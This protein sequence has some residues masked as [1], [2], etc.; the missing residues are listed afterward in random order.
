ME[1]ERLCSGMPQPRL[2][3]GI[4]L[5]LLLCCY[6]NFSDEITGVLFWFRYAYS[7]YFCETGI[8]DGVDAHSVCTGI[9]MFAELCAHEQQLFPGEET[10]EEGKL[11]PLPKTF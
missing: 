11:G 5:L 2:S 9:E 3:H 4:Y 6:D 1:R 8:T 10:F 7:F